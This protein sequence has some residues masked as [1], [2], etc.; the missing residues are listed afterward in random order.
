MTTFIAL[1]DT[2][3]DFKYIKKGDEIEAPDDFCSPN[4]KRKDGKPMKAAEAGKG[5]AQK[6]IS[7]GEE[8]TQNLNET[9]IR[10]KAK[11]LKINNW[12][13]KKP[14]DLLAEIA[15]VEAENAQPD[16]KPDDQN[17]N[18]EQPE[19]PDGSDSEVDNSN[20]DNSEADKN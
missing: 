18:N 4:F 3:K 15:K 14:Q 19:N 2:F 8:E 9:E 7:K 13:T 1:N 12:W 11:S 16:F 17:D 20:V 6:E 10:A 5:A